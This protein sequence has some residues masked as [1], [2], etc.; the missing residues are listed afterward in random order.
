MTRISETVEVTKPVKEKTLKAVLCDRCGK[1][2]FRRRY[3]LAGTSVEFHFGYGSS[4]D[5]EW[6]K[7]DVCD[8]CCDWLKTEFKTGD[9][10][11]R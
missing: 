8:E 5:D 11:E 9:F 1:D 10:D 7:L 3:E 4:H 6:W 2:F